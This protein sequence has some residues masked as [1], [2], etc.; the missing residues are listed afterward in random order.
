MNLSKYKK[1]IEFALRNKYRIKVHYTDEI[2]YFNN[3]INWK[4][5]PYQIKNFLI[6]KIIQEIENYF[7]NSTNFLIIMYFEGDN[8]VHKI[9]L[10]LPQLK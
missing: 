10:N 1:D 8:V 5:P 7:K 6:D 9:P 2:D 3:I 4:Y